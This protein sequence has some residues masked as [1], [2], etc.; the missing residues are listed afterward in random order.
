MNDSPNQPAGAF[1]IADVIGGPL[2]MIETALP[3]TAFVVAYAVSGSAT[4]TAAIIAVGVAVLLAIGRLL[5]RQT[6]RHA[7]SGLIGVG[8]AAF[9][10]ART[11]R[12]ENFFLPGL[13]INAAYVAA[14]VISIL[15]RRPLVGVLLTVLGRETDGWRADR[16]RMRTFNRASWMW[17]GLFGLRLVVQLPL[18]FAGAVLALGVAR[19]AMNLPLLALGIW[20]TWLQVRRAPAAAA[21]PPAGA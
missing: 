1:E 11:G 6:A 20:A 21:I 7:L 12:A 18:Y 17:A 3:G 15:V 4:E 10:A 19:T 16:A 9:I 8:F 13:F 14:F 2:G 5:R